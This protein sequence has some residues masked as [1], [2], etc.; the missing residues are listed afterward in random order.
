MKGFE[1]RGCTCRLSMDCLVASG[2]ILFL[3][4]VPGCDLDVAPQGDEAQEIVFQQQADE[5]EQIASAMEMSLGKAELGKWAAVD[6]V[7]FRHGISADVRS[8]RV[9]TISFSYMFP[10]TIDGREH[11]NLV[12][13][14]GR[15]AY[16]QGQWQLQQ[17]AVAFKFFNEAEFTD[18]TDLL[19]TSLADG[20]QLTQLKTIWESTVRDTVELQLAEKLR[21]QAE[22]KQA[23]EE[24]AAEKQAEEDAETEAKRVR[25]EALTASARLALM[26][27]R[28][29]KIATKAHSDLGATVE[30]V[31]GF[32]FTGGFDVKV[33]RDD[34][35]Y[36]GRVSFEAT[37]RAVT[38]EYIAARFGRPWVYGGV[39][40]DGGWDA[41]SRATLMAFFNKRLAG[42]GRKEK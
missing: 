28:L 21:L 13:H 1:S 7:T 8:P 23:D 42:Q 9:A 3:A 18:E 22:E 34:D 25:S 31:E 15:L 5:I 12:R 27:A 41:A 11:E 37:P 16:H 39:E 14:D 4:I 24:A 20:N 30:G 29:K 36:L 32:R 26:T 2:T 40:S 10:I 17:V 33:D 35:S 6:P 19:V 38:I